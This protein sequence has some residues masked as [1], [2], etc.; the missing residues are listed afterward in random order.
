MFSFATSRP[1]S[2]A[3]GVNLLMMIA[4]MF[5]IFILCMSLWSIA[6]AQGEASSAAIPE[7]EWYNPEIEPSR[8]PLSAKVILSGRT[9]PGATVRIDLESVNSLGEPAIAASG[10]AKKTRYLRMK[11]NVYENPDLSSNVVT[12]LAKD[13]RVLTQ[14]A[15]SGWV[16]VFGKKS[17]AFIMEPCL[18][19]PGS[20]PL[21]SDGRSV[22]A[23][24]DGFFE[25]AMELPQGLMQIPVVIQ[26]GKNA[27]K[28]FLVSVD[29]SVKK[30]EVKTT[31]KVS[32]KKP[33]AAGKKVRIWTG[34]GFTYQSNNQTTEGSPTL[35]F[36][37][38]Q[39]PGI[40]WR[41]G[42]WGDQWGLDFYFRDAP[43]TIQADA[44]F[45]IQQS[46]YHWRTT[47]AKGLY[48]IPRTSRSRIWGLPSQWQIRFGT[49]IH[50]VPFMDIDNSNVVTIRD[51][52]LTM[53]TLGVGL[54]LGQE[55]N[56]CYEFAFSP[57]LPISASGHGDS[58]SISTKLAYEAQIG[59]AY[60]LAPNW[61]LGVFSY[62]QSLSYSYNFQ[63]SGSG[64]KTGEQNLF[65]TTF[66][67]RLGYEF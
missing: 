32:A 26:S 28:T 36:K 12:T 45:Q 16:Q 9:L 31:T 59:A 3:N 39:A 66:D 17:V 54:L 19:L 27:T 40:M 30:E 34:L 41:A 5:S 52:T 62:V 56:W 15:S 55:R 8:D 38:M 64:A 23:N 35:E 21:K 2:A 22:R 51:H 24:S 33:P 29:V 48:Q 63:K 37:T 57:Q 25:I 18:T 7:V 20:G 58:F 61:R 60:K 67:L 11:C 4:K 49:Q 10:E 53:A 50:Q 43:G 46:T 65:Y 14:E 13:T 42:Y 1:K 47:E 44:P 6:L